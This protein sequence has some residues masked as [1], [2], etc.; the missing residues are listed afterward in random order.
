MPNIILFEQKFSYIINH[1]FIRSLTLR[2][3]S[4]HS[5]VVSCPHLT[6]DFVVAKFIQDH[7]SWIVK[8]ASHL[9]ASSRLYSLNSLPIL[10][11]NYK[12]FI[13]KTARDSLVIFKDEQK[14]YANTTS[15]SDSHLKTL[16]DKK[17]RPLAL[18]LI[19]N[20]L[21]QLS[22]KYGFQYHHVTVRNTVS[23]YGSCSRSGNLNFNWQI[24]FF[25]PEIFRHILLHEL[26]HLKIKNHSLTFWHQLAIYDPHCGANRL[27]LKKEGNKTMIFSLT[28]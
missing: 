28:K 2:L 11:Q 23:R 27:W 19:K 13:S 3:K 18:S 21:S 8:N 12:I 25:P 16:F 22:Q 26:T 17:L 4:P 24:I 9:K 20:E 5:F 14:I 6:P 10:D 1:K 15:F 7:S